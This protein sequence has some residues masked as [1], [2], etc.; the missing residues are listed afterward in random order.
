MP[1]ANDGSGHGHA[2][3]RIHEETWRARER[4]LVSKYSSIIDQ[5][6]QEIARQNLVIAQLQERERAPGASTLC[7]E[8]DGDGGTAQNHNETLHAIAAALMRV[9]GFRPM[10]LQHAMKR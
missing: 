3:E 10:L 5:L 6:Q 1:L 8:E 7:S 4:E 9:A 2:G